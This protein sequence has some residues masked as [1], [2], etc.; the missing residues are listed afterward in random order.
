MRN[1]RTII[2]DA[3]TYDSTFCRTNGNRDYL[4][5]GPRRTDDTMP[6]APVRCTNKFGA[7]TFNQL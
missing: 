1:R 2:S 6:D 4:R 3:R 7:F 5:T